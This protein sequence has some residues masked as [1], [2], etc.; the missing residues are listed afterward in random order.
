MNMVFFNGACILTYGGFLFIIN[1][2][3]PSE[4]KKPHKAHIDADRMYDTDSA[5][6]CI[7]ASP[8]SIVQLGIL[9]SIM[10]DKQLLLVRFI[11]SFTMQLFIQ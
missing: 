4:P 5:Y 1:D 2:G 9:G 10:I 3:S 11:F 8:Q 6:A 7:P